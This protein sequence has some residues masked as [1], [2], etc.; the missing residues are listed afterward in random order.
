M[1][2]KPNDS[3]LMLLK[4][5]VWAHLPRHERGAHGTGDG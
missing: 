1:N 4:N 2:A 5:K 3:D